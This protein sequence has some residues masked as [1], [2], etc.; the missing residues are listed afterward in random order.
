MTSAPPFAAPSHRSLPKRTALASL[1]LACAVLGC[2]GSDLPGEDAYDRAVADLALGSAAAERV[3]MAREHVA[4]DVYH[5][6]IDLR[7]G[8]APNARIRVHRVVRES[9]PFRARPTNEAVMME[10]GSF[11]TFTSNFLSAPRAGDGAR[12][13]GLAVY[14]AARGVDVWGMD[15]RWAATPAGP[16]DV[17]DFPS[18]GFATSIADIRTALA[19]ARRVREWSGTGGDRLTLLG[20][21]V[22]A[23]LTYAYAAAESALSPR[24]RHVKAI[25]PIDVYAKIAPENEDLRK[26]ACKRRDQ[27]R[28][29]MAGGLYDLDNTFFQQMGTSS[30]TAPADPSPFWPGLT[31]KQAV[32]LFVGQ[33]YLYYAVTPVYHL[34]GGELEG[35]SIARLRFAPD[36]RVEDWLIGAP[37]HEAYAESVDMDAILCG[38]APLPVEDRFADI[39][40]PIFYLGAA[41]GFGDYGLHSTRITRAS[42]VTTHVVR[43]L[44][45]ALEAA[46]YGHADLL[47]GSDAPEIAWQPLVAW[48]QR[49]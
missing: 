17:S 24:E 23:L 36:G 10:H 48:L 42:D 35:D 26:E 3:E 5:Y 11:A 33:T 44:P 9:A 46:D 16:V 45:P 6:S 22:G 8:D 29:D 40:V 30:R 2:S 25:V 18:L 47:F 13:R 41:G 21:S 4:G 37:P 7:V 1:A 14:L 32:H 49:R 38:E 20:F 31:N 34:N 39:R 15:R 12:H 19:L 27:G 43:R 28:A